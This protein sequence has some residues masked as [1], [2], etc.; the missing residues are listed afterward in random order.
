MVELLYDYQAN[1]A[2]YP[3]WQAYFREHQPPT[4]IVWGRNDPFFTAAGARAYLRDL[5]RAELHLLDGG[6]FALEEH[7]GFIAE[8]IAG[9]VAGQA[10]LRR[11]PPT[12]P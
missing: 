12:G 6:H 8:R 3:Q 7:L 1:T 11:T 4:L 5:P 10:Q 9:F 2:R